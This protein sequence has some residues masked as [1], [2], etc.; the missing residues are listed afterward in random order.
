LSVVA[1]LLPVGA[2]NERLP[3][4]EAV[5]APLFTLIKA[6]LAEAVA[7]DPSKKSSVGF[8]SKIA[9]DPSLNGEPPLETGR[10]PVIY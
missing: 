3:A 8:L 7:L 5:G 6:N 9:P 2:A 4:I 1:G 10:I